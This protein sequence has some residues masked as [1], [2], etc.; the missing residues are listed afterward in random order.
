MIVTCD[1]CQKNFDIFEEG[2]GT[3]FFKVCGKC[4]GT[5]LKLRAV[6]GVFVRGDK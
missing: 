4:W 2:H 5:E 6:G 1:D 3:V